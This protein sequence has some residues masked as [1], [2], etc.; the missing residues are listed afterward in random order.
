MRKLS[1]G[2]VILTA[3]DLSNFLACDHLTQLS[4]R[5]A[6][7]EDLP[8]SESEMTTLLSEAGARHEDDTLNRLVQTGCTI[9][10]FAGDAS[11]TAGTAEELARAAADTLD[12][13]REGWDVI[14]QPTFFDGEWV[15]RADFLFKV[16][17]PST[18]GGHSYEVA[19]A[20]LARHVRAEALL[21]LSEYSFQVARLQGRAPER[22]RVLLGDGSDRAH[23]VGDFAAY[24]MS[25]RK[26]LLEAVHGAPTY[27]LKV[28]HCKVCVYADLCESKRRGDDH[29]S[30]VARMRNDQI[31]KLESVRVATLT[32]LAGLPKD[33]DVPRLAATTLE[34]L[35]LQ[36]S[37]QL[38]GREAPGSAP[39]VELLHEDTPGFG[40][41][42]LPAPSPG[43]VFFDMEG[44]PLA[45]DQPLEYLFGAVTVEAGASRY[46]SWLGHD[47]REEKAAFEGFMDWLMARL[48]QHPDLHVYHYAAYERSAL[49]N[50]M[51]R[52][53]TRESE[54]DQLLRR[55][56]LVDLYRVVRQGVRLST[57]SYGLKEVERLYLAPR[58]E[59]IA[60]AQGS[61]VAYEKW[62]SSGLTAETRD[63]R[64]LD[65]IIEYN[66]VDCVSTW[67][68]RDW[69]EKQ[70]IQ[71]EHEHTAP[72]PRPL[73]PESTVSATLE[74]SV[75]AAEDMRSRLTDSIPDDPVERTREQAA[76]WLLAQLLGYHRRENKV[77]W[78][79]YFRELEMTREELEE[80]SYALG[81]LT[82]LGPV[83]TSESAT[84]MR[85]Q[86]APQEHRI[87]EDAKPKALPIRAGARGPDGAGVVVAIDNAAGTIDVRRAARG[88]EVPHPLFLIPEP[89]WG[90][91][92]H[93]QAL[94]EAGAWVE[95]HGIDAAGEHRAC[96]DLLLRNPPRMRTATSG[97]LRRA[98]ESAE[99]AAVRV[100]R[101]LDGGCLAIQGPPGAGK[102]YTAARIALELAR[103]GR[104]VAV[105]ATAHKA[106]ANLLDE[107]SRAARDANHPL[108]LMQLVRTRDRCSEPDVVI[109]TDNQKVFAA[110]DDDAVDIVGATTWLLVA[111]SAAGQF[112]TLIVD[113]AGQMSLA[114]VVAASRC[115]RN[116]V[117]VGDPRQLAQVVQGTHPTGA[118]VSGLEHLLGEDITIPP[119]RGIFL[120]RTW[121]MAPAV[122]SFVSTS[123]YQGR[124]EPEPANAHQAILAEG[125]EHAGLRLAE[126]AHESDRTYSV[127]EAARV[128]EIVAN[129]QRWRWR[130]RTGQVRPI[131][132]DDILVVAPYN[133][134]VA[135]LEQALPE[136]ARVGTVDKFQ[137]QEAPVSI[138]S[139]ATS[140]TEDLPR[141]LEFLYSMNR[142]NVAVS[143]ARCLSVLV[144][145][146]QLL[147]A[148]CHTP[149][150]MRLVNALCRYQQM[151][152]PWDPGATPVAAPPAQQL[153]LLMATMLPA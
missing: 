59:S 103:H 75:T 43:D 41:A 127:A 71:W 38:R 61:V 132:L 33:V 30:L 22:M 9:K 66:E 147:R 69:L 96:R 119:D 84:V 68:L 148:R 93:A 44:D 34:S 153:P 124:L 82:L 11:R 92:G 108:R 24:H 129:L 4:L 80:D 67:R 5:A 109:A 133:A 137:G 99:Q 78:W 100:V 95:A 2:R 112:D 114:D 17:T 152:Q 106:I 136:G 91:A 60:D 19:D 76:T 10:Q 54:V 55:G 6:L 3:T 58:G 63:Q 45:R 28:A 110:L 94:L 70:R 62:L 1:D 32:E 138:F 47:A 79:R 113:E 40:L 128:A 8:R 107:V 18:L 64:L 139:M 83:E 26:Q 15:G 101:D 134:H 135:C 72:L 36:A 27:P 118:G 20:K 74:E 73:P 48:A 87:R 126:V 51:G 53:A 50:L 23:L 150:Q 104:R 143:R 39:L 125:V 102:T 90:T 111:D 37:L 65:G 151:A 131:H 149:E 12:A 29:L 46:H 122:C 56:V 52:H 115:A 21:Q 145:S 86:F 14:Y 25:V 49:L 144:C 89:P 57:E 116:I 42:A 31:H 7:G 81:P 120:D 13:M 121:R 97:A 146:P 98:D 141:N 117:L 77:E 142:L 35:R 88:G 85:Y 130:D 140:S 105:T 16:K 123:F